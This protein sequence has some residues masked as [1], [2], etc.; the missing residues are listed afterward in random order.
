MWIID[1][2]V[3]KGLEG[4][5]RDSEAE[6]P[7]YAHGSSESSNDIGNEGIRTYY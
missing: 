7:K 4:T 2:L 6:A 1:T 3:A 5:L